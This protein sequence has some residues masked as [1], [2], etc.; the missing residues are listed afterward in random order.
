M[1]PQA[2]DV[3]YTEHPLLPG[4]PMFRC[5][6]M[7]ASL[8]VSRCAEMWLASNQGKQGAQ[9]RCRACPIG[10]RHAGAGDPAMHWLRGVPVCSRCQRTGMRLIG[11]NICVSCQNR[12]YEWVKG[13]NAKG[14]FPTRHAPME[15][16]RVCV[17]M[18]GEVRTV[19]RQLTT[20]TTELV[21]EL[22]RDSA[23]RVVF[24]LG[25]GR[26]HAAN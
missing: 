5:Q 18:G 4:K 1:H 21:V 24:G 11:G 10:A 15:P 25:R 2:P 26:V 22:L 3:E 9:D 12:Q 13:V 7:A 17:A 19:E 14:K 16:R 6:K 20:S 8:Q 23:E